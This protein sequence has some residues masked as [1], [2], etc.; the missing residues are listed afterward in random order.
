M[1]VSQLNL[2]TI[3][4]CD[5]TTYKLLS[6]TSLRAHVRML[7]TDQREVIFDEDGKEKKQ[8][9]RDFDISLGTEPDE[10]IEVD[11]LS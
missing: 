1:F 2:G 7:K 10:I 3:F 4:R 5:K 8:Q 6:L 11:S 9:T